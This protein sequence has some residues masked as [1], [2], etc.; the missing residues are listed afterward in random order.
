V[1]GANTLVAK[2]TVDVDVDVF[3]GTGAPLAG[4]VGVIGVCKYDGNPVSAPPAIVGAGSVLGYYDVYVGTPGAAATV[5]IKIYGP[6]TPYTK[7]YYGGALG[8]S[9]GEPVVTATGAPAW[10]VNVL[11]GYAYINITNGSTPNILGLAGTPFALVEDKTVAAPN[12]SAA[13]GGN[14]VIGAYDISIEPMF[15]WQAVPGAIR[16]ELA[17]CEDPT[18]AVIER[19]YAPEQP[20]VKVEEA[21]RYSTT[22]YWRVRGVLGEPEG[23]GATRVTPATPWTVG[24]F[25]TMDEPV[26]A[27]EA[28]VVE[29]TAP[30]VTVDVAPTEV[31]IQPSS[32]AIPT[33]ML[34]VIVAVG[35]VLIIA[36]IVLIVRTRRVV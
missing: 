26:E 16:Y 10:G 13:A 18:F 14:P 15:T 25:T 3:D 11:G 7:V 22:Y 19:N 31:T 27:G 17:I 1:A 32:P 2:T 23:S 8:G 36:L 28:V 35:A 34:W 20:F 12:I 24:I 4:G 30:E 21:L 6:V 9:W 29:P 5:Q 33:Y